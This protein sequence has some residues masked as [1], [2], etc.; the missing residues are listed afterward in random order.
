MSILLPGQS[1][2]EFNLRD[3][4]GIG[5]RLSDYRGI[6]VILC[7]LPTDYNNSFI[8]AA[9]ALRDDFSLIQDRQAELFGINLGGK[10]A[11]AHLSERY[12]LSFP[13]LTDKWG[14]VCERYNALWSLGPLKVVRRNSI[15]VNPSGHI[16]R[17]Y[18]RI[19][20]DAHSKELIRDLD[21]LQQT[22]FRLPKRSVGTSIN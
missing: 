10:R 6:W 22:F 19:N 4:Y 7:F 9:C 13:L 17:I 5:H 21:L 3:Q 11:H 8:K 16:M 18:K 12:G 20:P 14:K 1:A 2:P 15:I